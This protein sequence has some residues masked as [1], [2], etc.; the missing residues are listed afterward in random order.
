MSYNGVIGESGSYLNIVLA[1]NLLSEIYGIVTS[2][3][4][5]RKIKC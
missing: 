2:V 4:V 3:R 5:Y 1:L